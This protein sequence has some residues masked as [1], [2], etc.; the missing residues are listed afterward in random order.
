MSLKHIFTKSLESCADVAAQGSSPEVCPL[1]GSDIQSQFSQSS[2]ERIF[3]NFGAPAQCNGTVTSWHYYSYNR[4]LEEDNVCGDAER[5]TSKF[6]VYRQTG[7]STYEPVP[8]STK[9]VTITLR[10]PSHGG[11]RSRVATLTQS[12][13]FTIQQND[14]VAACVMDTGSTDPLRIVGEGSTQSGSG[15]VYHYDV[16]GYQ[17]CT[18]SEL[19]SIDTQN[20]DFTSRNGIYRLHLY[21]E[22]SSKF[23]VNKD[24]QYTLATP[25][26]YNLVS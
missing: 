24:I 14:I 22:V 3:L 4:Y 21:A 17:S 18:T 6:L 7:N 9:S 19:Q 1:L 10:C 15:Q 5:Y 25:V 20:P 12:E 8:G 23:T 11:F 26:M 16:S 13:Q 2:K